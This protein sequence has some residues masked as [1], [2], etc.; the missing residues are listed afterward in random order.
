[1]GSFGSDSLNSQYGLVGRRA[2]ALLM[3]LAVALLVT[4]CSLFSGKEIDPTEGWSASKL[5]AEA[6][7]EMEDKNWSATLKLLESLQSRYPFGRFAQQALM[8]S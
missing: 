6:Q 7:L 5:Y 1:M 4:G 2:R 8:S 3:M